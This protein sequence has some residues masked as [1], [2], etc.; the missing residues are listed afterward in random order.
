MASVEGLR[1]HWFWSSDRDGRLNYVSDWLPDDFKCA[2]EDLLGKE[3]KAIFRMEQVGEQTSLGYLLVKKKAFRGVN[4]KVVSDTSERVWTVSANPIVDDH[5][6]FCGFSGI[7]TDITAA[8]ESAQEISRLASYDPLT[9]L[10][11]RRGM[12]SLVERALHVSEQQS[13]PF[14]I[15]LIDL[16]RFKQ[17]N[18]ALG[19][20]VGDALLQ[21]VAQRLQLVVRDSDCV[22]RIGG[23][24]FEVVLANRSHREDLGFLADAIIAELSKPYN[25]NGSRCVIGASIGLVVAPEDGKTKDELARN[26]DLALYAAKAGGRGRHKFFAREMHEEAEDRRQ[27]EQDL[28]DAVGRNELEV[29]YQPLV[30]SKTNMVTGFEA[31]LRWNH[32]QRG[33]ISP[34]LFVPIAEDANLITQLG[35]WVM[36]QA[37]LDASTWPENLRVAVNVSPIQFANPNLTQVVTSALANANLT[38]RRLELEITESVFLGESSETEQTFAAL[39][40]IGV[41][42]ALDDFGTGYSSLGYLKSAPFDKIK[43]DQSFVRGSPDPKSR[44]SAIIKSIVALAEAMDMETT[45]EGIETLDQLE[46]MRA[47]NVSHIQGYLYSLPVAASVVTEKVGDGQWEIKPIGPAK[48][49]GPRVATFRRIAAVHGNHYYPVIL[50]NLSATGA[51]IEGMAEVPVG[52]RFVLDFGNCQWIVATVKRSLG[53]YQGLAFDELLVSDEEGGFRPKHRV[54]ALTMAQIGLKVPGA[55]NKGRDEAPSMAAVENFPQFRTTL[56]H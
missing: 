9:G 10:R 5:G 1:T 39:K 23:D 19:H 6:E 26:V 51:L 25:V 45:A 24:E 35:E 22:G 32:P 42:L 56:V 31:L 47:L 18:D 43:I 8:Q 44:N 3:L 52:T 11:N 50:R 20:P 46:T 38:P 36:R 14:S 34:A 21:Q 49:R 33:R 40:K 16:D 2:P 4:I 15:M 55:A 13:T 28:L 54:S 30:C 37:C 7:G 17:V 12:S 27:L 48:Q 53:D 29:N 41:R